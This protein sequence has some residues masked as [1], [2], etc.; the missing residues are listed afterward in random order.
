MAPES[1][2]HLLELSGFGEL[3][4]AAFF[5]CQLSHRVRFLVVQD[6]KGSGCQVRS[7]S[8]AIERFGYGIDLVHFRNVE[9]A[10]GGKVLFVLFPVGLFANA[11]FYFRATLTSAFCLRTTLWLGLRLSI[12]VSSSQ[13]L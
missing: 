2:C 7:S 5:S 6:A 10:L 3:F 11:S 8:P 13:P 9:A 12:T 1:M 4:Y